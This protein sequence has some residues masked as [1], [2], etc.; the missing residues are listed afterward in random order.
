MKF[1][2]YAALIATTQAGPFADKVKA[3]MAK[4]E[5]VA[6]VEDTVVGWFERA[7]QMHYEAAPAVERRND[8]WASEWNQAAHRE[9][10]IVHDTMKQLESNDRRAMEQWTKSE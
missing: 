8:K 7:E 10:I 5:E 3:K 6:K 4:A 1:S 2:V 9:D